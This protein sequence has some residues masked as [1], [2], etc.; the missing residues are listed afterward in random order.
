MPMLVLGARLERALLSERDFKSLSCNGIGQANSL[1]NGSDTVN[2]GQ[3]KPAKTR[4]LASRI[5]T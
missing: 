4:S 2:S 1:P 5:A 3:Q